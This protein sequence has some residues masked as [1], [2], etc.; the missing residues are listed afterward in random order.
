MKKVRININPD[1]CIG[2]R[3]CAILCPEGVL[4]LRS[5][6]MS[7]V[8]DIDACTI[9]MLCENG[10]PENAIKVSQD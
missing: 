2:C 3:W 5:E 10:C 9:C 7:V 6:I 4:A 8:V 1:L